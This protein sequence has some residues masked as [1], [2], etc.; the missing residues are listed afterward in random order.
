[1]TDAGTAR[2]GLVLVFITLLLDIVGIGIIMPVL[3]AYLHELTGASISE[4]AIEGGWLF[5]VTR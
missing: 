3:P 5:F 2:R 1:M 4:A